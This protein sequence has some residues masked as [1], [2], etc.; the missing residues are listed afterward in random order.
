MEIRFVCRLSSSLTTVPY[1]DDRVRDDMRELAE[2]RWGCRTF[3][4]FKLH[5][6]INARCAGSSF[7]NIAFA[8]SRLHRASSR[9]ETHTTVPSNAAC[10]FGDGQNVVRGGFSRTNRHVAN[11]CRFRRLASS[12]SCKNLRFHSSKS[13]SFSKSQSSSCA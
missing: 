5:P 12:H 7:I 10:A 3:Q 4:S 13:T 8:A 9:D 1:P 11:K 6:E 2:T